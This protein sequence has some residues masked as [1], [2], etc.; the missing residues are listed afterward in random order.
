LSAIWIEI[1][2]RIQREDVPIPGVLEAKAHS[3]N[4]SSVLF[5]TIQSNERM[6]L[7]AS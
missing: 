1:V 5:D 6:L 2:I 7:E 4:D 3:T